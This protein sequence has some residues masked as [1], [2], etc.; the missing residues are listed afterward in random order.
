[1]SF[2]GNLA[3]AAGNVSTTPV[4]AKGGWLY[5][6]AVGGTFDGATVKIETHIPAPVS[7][8]IQVGSNI[9]AASVQN[10]ELPSG[11]EVRLTISGGGGSVSIN[12]SL[13][14]LRNR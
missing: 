9:T 14:L 3:S 2:I 4:I 6:I 1:M 10:I 7:A 12:G 8:W 5:Q 13:T 11:R